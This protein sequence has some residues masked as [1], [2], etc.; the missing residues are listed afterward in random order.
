MRGSIML[1]AVALVASPGAVLA[2]NDPACAK[3]EEPLAYNACLASR[4]PRA[5]FGS[6][7]DADGQ[8]APVRAQPA[9]RPAANRGWGRETRRHGR[10]HMEFRLK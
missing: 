6:H 9:N 2:E 7:S 8:T 1:L 3:Y 10:V 5:N 4:G